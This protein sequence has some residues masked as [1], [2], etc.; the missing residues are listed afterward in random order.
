MLKIGEAVSDFEI[1]FIKMEPKSFRQVGN[2]IK[3]YLD[4]TKL[5]LKKYKTQRLISSRYGR[6][7]FTAVFLSLTK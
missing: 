1:Q 6:K 2:L 3:E 7:L 4:L 5:W